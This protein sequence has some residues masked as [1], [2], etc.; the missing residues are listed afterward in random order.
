MSGTKDDNPDRLDQLM[1][2]AA[3]QG[4]SPQEEVEL[5]A[6]LAR[7]ASLRFEAEAYELTATE[8]ELAL[9]K[10]RQ[11]EALPASLREKLIASAP[12]H[13][14]LPEQGPRL[15]LAG[16]SAQIDTQ[17]KAAFSWTDGRAF[18]WY[19]AAAAVVA[20][21]VLLLQ[22]PPTQVIEKIVEKEVPGKVEVAKAPPLTDQYAELA[23]DPD[24]VRAD[25][26][27]NAQDGDARFANAAGEVIWNSGKQTGYM[28]LEGLP[29]N[30]PTAEQ[31]QLWIVDGTRA[32]EFTDRIDGG[33][34]DVTSE[35]EVIIP[36]DAKITAR[37]P[38]VFAITAE[39]PGGV[40]KSEGTLQ[41]IAAV[42]AG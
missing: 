30:D 41:V 22:P 26:G 23:Q 6:E 36:I 3:T 11:D 5:A 14:S 8:I 10:P 17:S 20:V 28:K 37:K 35:G 4:L 19:A 12:A 31:Y 7:D 40:V 25:W 2:D 18:G 9:I 13:L 27:F 1:V 42:E 32:S 29:V 21:C 24:T 39:Q 38:V 33:V 15:Q 34:F 16:T